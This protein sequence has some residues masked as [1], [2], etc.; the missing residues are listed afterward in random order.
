MRILLD[1]SL[2]K[3]PQSELPGHDVRTVQDMGRSGV[4]NGDLL[5]RSVGQFDVFLTA[6]QNLRYQQ[7]LG[8]LPIRCGVGSEEQSHSGSSS[9]YSQ[10]A[11]RFRGVPASHFCRDRRLTHPAVY[12]CSNL[13]SL[14]NGSGNLG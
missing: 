2:P 7:N 13:G 6:D 4:K 1:E 10:V 8:A 14:I 5:A 12:D 3:E 11:C 9:V